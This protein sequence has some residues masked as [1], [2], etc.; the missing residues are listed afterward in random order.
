[1]SS[2]RRLVAR[3]TSPERSFFA[4]TSCTTVLRALIPALSWAATVIAPPA[5][6][7]P[8][9][10]GNSAAVNSIAAVARLET[11][12]EASRMPPAAPE[13]P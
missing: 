2:L 4:T 9:E 6:T 11:L 7:T 1:M 12:L 3:S 13:A 10:S 5:V 8:W